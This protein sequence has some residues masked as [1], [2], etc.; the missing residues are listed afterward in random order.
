MGEAL[1]KTNVIYDRPG[2]LVLFGV[3]AYAVFLRR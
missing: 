2:L 1:I 3:G